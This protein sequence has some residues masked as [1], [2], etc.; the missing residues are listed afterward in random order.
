MSE[1]T[2]T[3]YAPPPISGYRELTQNEVNL[4]NEIK[5]KGDDL[6]NLIDLLD[7]RHEPDPRWV[8]IGRTHAQQAIMALVRSVAK[9]QG[10]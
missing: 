10:F 6:G 3:T 2:E 8:S 5:Q 4:I 9:P 7:E 1:E